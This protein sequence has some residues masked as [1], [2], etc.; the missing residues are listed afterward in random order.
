[1]STRQ[2]LMEQYEDA[3]FAVI[4]NDIMAEEGKELLKESACL[5]AN[6][7]FTVPE[8]TTR[9]C[10]NAIARDF[11][12][13]KRAHAAHT[14]WRVFQRVAVAAFVAMLLFTGVCAAFPSVRNAALNLLIGVSDVY[15]DMRFG[16]EVQVDAP[17][18][19][20]EAGIYE[21]GVLPDGFVLTDSGGDSQSY[22][23]TYSNESSAR[24]K[25]DVMNS[26]VDM[27]HRFDTE[28]MDNAE[29]I[30]VNG[31]S[32]LLAV[33]DELII[34]TLAD[35]GHHIFIDIT[36]QGLSQEELLNI[37]SDLVYTE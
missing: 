1:M 12:K 26:S 11:G 30:E 22:W 29:N 35:E 13:Q 20:A 17:V 27:I 23:R 37:L 10:L 7:G 14:A 18:E 16:E 8:E 2:R 25:L 31:N 32:G 24:I 28:S 6:P 15:T 34:A 33:K 5:K 4:M 21:F 9:R 19:A 3:L 36:C